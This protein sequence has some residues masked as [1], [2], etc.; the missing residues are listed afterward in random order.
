MNIKQ[1]IIKD[2]NE[3]PRNRYNLQAKNCDSTPT[4][5]KARELNNK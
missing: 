5:L 2:K 3:M 1:K 4:L